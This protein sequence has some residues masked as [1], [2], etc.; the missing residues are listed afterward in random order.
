MATSKKVVTEAVPLSMATIGDLDN[1]V[2]GLLVDKEIDAL[3]KDLDDRAEEDGKARHL[4]IDI[5]VVVTK[6]IVIMTPKV[7]AKLPPR[8]SNSTA[9][10]GRMRD[11]GQMELLFQANNSDNA[12]QGTL[13]DGSEE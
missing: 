6:G 13:D 2:F 7:A 8:V 3:V 4:C 12:D 5:E 1:G 9:G 11:K 10:K